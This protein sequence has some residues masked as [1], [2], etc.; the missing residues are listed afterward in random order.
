MADLQRNENYQA[1]LG[2]LKNITSTLANIKYTPPTP[3]PRV[4]RS[5]PTASKTPATVP[6]GLKNLGT[7]TTGYKTDSTR[8]EKQHMGLDIANKEGTNIPSF[9]GGKVVEAISGKSWTQNTPSYG[10]QIVVQ[11]ESGNKWYYSHLYGEYKKIGD[12]VQ[13]G[14]IIAT[15]GGTGSTYSN[16]NPGTPG[17]HLDLRIKNLA[18]QYL[19][20]LSVIK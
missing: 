16:A 4:A 20:P 11:D 9:S 17:Y 3:A 13:P 12:V 1:A 18:G 5:V 8:Y 6:Q 7:I 2:N 19:D 15:I 14:E 10:N